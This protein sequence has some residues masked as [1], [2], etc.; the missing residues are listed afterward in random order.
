MSHASHSAKPAK[1]KRFA[2][3]RKN[4]GAFWSVV[5]IGG[6]LLVALLFFVGTQ[7]PSW[8][9]P[10]TGK[11]M[12]PAPSPTAMAEFGVQQ[13]DTLFGGECLTNYTDAWDDYFTVAPCKLDHEAQLVFRG[14]FTEVDYPGEEE[15]ASKVTAL[16]MRPGILDTA[17]AASYNDL[18]LQGSF[19]ANAEQWEASR[20]YYCF[21]SRSSGDPIAGGSLQGT[22]PDDIQTSE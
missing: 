1:G 22:G 9:S 2:A 6:A 5:S 14:D 21:V 13:W 11:K 17:N 19:P 3:F 10:D 12:E 20:A 7:I 16:C 4:K 8:M 18:V 15:L